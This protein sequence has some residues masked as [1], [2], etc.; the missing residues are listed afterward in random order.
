MCVCVCTCSSLAALL[1]MLVNWKMLGLNF[2]CMSHS[3]STEPFVDSLPIPATER[4]MCS[5]KMERIEE[6]R[7]S[8]T[9]K[10]CSMDQIQRTVT[11]NICDS[12]IMFST[13]NIY[14]FNSSHRRDNKRIQ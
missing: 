13:L 10:G 9:S 7:R 5:E 6:S 2:S 1:T 12:K 3:K 4:A 11:E 8:T 14:L